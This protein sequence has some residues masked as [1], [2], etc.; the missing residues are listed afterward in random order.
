MK[1][2]E[3]ALVWACRLAVYGPILVSSILLLDVMLDGTERFGWD[4][5]TRFS[6]RDP[7]EAGI[8]AGLAGSL[9]MSMITAAVA[10]PIGI[11]TAIH[12]EELR[13]PGRMTRFIEINIANLAAI[14]SV[15]YGLFGLE[16]FVRSLA[17]G[18]SLISG[19]L[20]MALL[21]LPLVITSTRAALRSVPHP[22]RENGLALGGSRWEVVRAVILPVAFADIISGCIFAISRALG[23]A[24]PLLLIA[25]YTYVNFVP[26]HPGDPFT[27]LPLQ[28]FG[29]LVRPE[30][31]FVLDAAA[32][33]VVLVVTVASLNAVGLWVR[34]RFGYPLTY[35]AEPRSRD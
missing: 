33:I 6:A 9:L 2:S 16:I 20:T 34:R 19:G 8:A 21:V 11:A 22:L 15:V 4:F 10:L 27:V 5:L 1:R 31:G 12:L 17:L 29:W 18:R 23:E 25:T 14:P 7:W 26:T 3:R 28:I 24:A 30:P 32:G 35:A 13:P